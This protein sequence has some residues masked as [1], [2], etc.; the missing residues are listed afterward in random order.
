MIQQ[1]MIQYQSLDGELNR[2]E[3]DLRKNDSFIKRKQFKALSQECEDNL[4]KLDARAQELKNQLAQA[5]AAME[6]ITE[7][8]EEHSKEIGALEDVDELNYMN[9]QLTAQLAELTNVDKDIKRIIREGEEIAKSFDEINAKLPKIVLAYKKANEDF[10][11]ATEEVKPK[12]AELKVKQAELKKVIESSLFDIYKKIS[13]SGLHPVFV[14]L[15]DGCRCG[16]CQME[17]PKAVVDAQMAG[18]SYMRCE[19]CGRIIYRED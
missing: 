13:D 15:R 3:R 19:H 7:V 16:G 12:V 18:K 1:E 14:P 9:K 11:K 10:N 8:I 17:M 6:K 2:I 5:K 4:A